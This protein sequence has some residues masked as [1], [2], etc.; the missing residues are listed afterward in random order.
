MFKGRLVIEA[1]EATSDSV[2]GWICDPLD[3][4][5]ERSLPDI[6]RS[7][8][9]AENIMMTP[10]VPS[11]LTKKGPGFRFLCSCPQVVQPTQERAAGR[12]RL[13]I[14]QR[15]EFCLLMLDPDETLSVIRN[16]A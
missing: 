5:F 2:R 3:S 6:S 1:A 4:M 11:S 16:S 13:L 12:E 14:Y 7:N 8:G 15:Q 10:P 9:W